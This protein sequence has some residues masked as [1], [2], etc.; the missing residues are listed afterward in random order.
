MRKHRKKRVILAGLGSIG[1]FYLR[2]LKKN[3]FDYI[4]FD[5]KVKKKIL[6]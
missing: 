2:S 6:F 3:N 4:V 1:K 5:P